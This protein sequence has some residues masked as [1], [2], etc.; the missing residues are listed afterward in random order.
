MFVRRV[1]VRESVLI[2]RSRYSIDLSSE[3]LIRLFETDC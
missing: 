2:Y 1:C 3:V